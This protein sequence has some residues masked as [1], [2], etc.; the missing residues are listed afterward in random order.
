MMAVLTQS[1]KP[2]KYAITKSGQKRQRRSTVGWRILI[3][4]NN[5][6]KQW[7]TLRKMKETCPAQTAQYAVSSRLLYEPVFYW[8]APYAFKKCDTIISSVRARIGKATHKYGIRIPR[9]ISKAILI[10]Q[11]NKNTLLR[12]SID[13]EMNTILLAFGILLPGQNPP[14][15]YTKSSG[16]IIFRKNGFH[17]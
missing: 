13:L 15:R 14:P 17:L 12:D 7:V 2:E 1:A 16:H 5:G 6:G 4:W 3:Q 8:W 11:E 10:D 9:S